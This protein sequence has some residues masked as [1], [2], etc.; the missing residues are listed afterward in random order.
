ALKYAKD[1]GKIEVLVES[2][3]DVVAITISD[4]GPGVPQEEQ[5]RIFER[6]YRGAA[7]GSTRARGSGIG[8]ALVRYIIESHGG[9]VQVISPTQPDGGG[10]KFVLE[11]PAITEL[12]AA[13]RA[14]P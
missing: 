1:G 10:T 4:F 2:K 3:G 7:A 6:F 8:L 11:V 13:R 5:A 12:A 14:T 9:R